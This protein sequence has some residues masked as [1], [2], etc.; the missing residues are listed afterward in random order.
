MHRPPAP[1]LDVP[2]LRCDVDLAV[3]RRPRGPTG[4]GW[5]LTTIDPD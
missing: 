5:S 3:V 2:G 1:H 4:V